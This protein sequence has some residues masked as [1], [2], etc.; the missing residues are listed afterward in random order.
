[1]RIRAKRTDFIWFIITVVIFVLAHHAAADE[2]HYNDFLIGE[3][4]AGMGGAYTAISD[5]PSGLY[6]NPAGTAYSVGNNLSASVNAYYIVRKKYD[7][8][9]SGKGWE[10]KGYS[11]LPNFFGIIQPAGPGKIGFSFAVPDSLKE[12]QDQDFNNVTSSLPD[13]DLSTLP[14][15]ND[16]KLP[17]NRYVI[18]FNNEDNTYQFGPSYAIEIG[19]QFAFGTTIYAHYRK[20]ERILNQYLTFDAGIT[21]GPITVNSETEWVNQYYELTEWGI[22]PVVGLMWSPKKQ[23]VALGFTMSRVFIL[24]SK[25]VVQNTCK[26]YD[27]DDEVDTNNDGI[28]DTL[29]PSDTCGGDPFADDTVRLDVDSSEKREYPYVLTLGAAYFPTNSLLVSGDISYYT[30]TSDDIVGDRRSFFNVALGA[31]YYV[32]SS[33]ALRGGAFTNA[34]STYSSEQGEHVNL[35]GGSLSVSYFTKGNSLTLGSAY[36]YGSGEAQIVKGL[37]RVQDLRT[38]AFVLYV[39]ASYA[40]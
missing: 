24:D 16:I 2:Y 17:I 9:I 25:A 12:E 3:R 8:V 26:G 6:Y 30:S 29:V 5:D 31:E 14:P 7:N 20:N 33:W 34:A 36:S 27:Y 19:D 21:S 18:N 35:Y 1:M 11:I 13:G 22:R 15:N 39:A 37:N 32:T 38:S 4:A 40:Y 10:R 23:K 28:P